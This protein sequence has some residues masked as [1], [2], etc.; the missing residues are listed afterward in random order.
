MYFLQKGSSGFSVGADKEQTL[1]SLSGS[2]EISFAVADPLS[3]LDIQGS[4]VNHA[5][6]CNL[7]PD[8]PFAPP[9]A[10]EFVAVSF[11]FPAIRAPDVFSDC[12]A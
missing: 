6:V 8:L 5:L 12:S 10:A 4:F 7:K 9:L 11:N 2:D 1:S 3:F